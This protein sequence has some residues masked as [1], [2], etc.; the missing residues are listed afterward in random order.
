MILKNLPN[1]MEVK[2]YFKDNF[3]FLHTT[4]SLSCLIGN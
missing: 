1:L 2:E 4:L 3:F